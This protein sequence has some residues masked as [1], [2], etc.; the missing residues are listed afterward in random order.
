[1]NIDKSISAVIAGLKI[2]GSYIVIDLSRHRRA[3]KIAHSDFFI[4]M[5]IKV[6]KA[7]KLYSTENS[8]QIKVCENSTTEFF[9]LFT[10]K[11]VGCTEF[12]LG[13]EVRAAFCTYS[14]LRKVVSELFPIP[15]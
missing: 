9:V 11:Y 2:E 15:L 7:D 1:M 14:R 5:Y 13:I 12:S 4:V 3:G 8:V 10:A 6:S